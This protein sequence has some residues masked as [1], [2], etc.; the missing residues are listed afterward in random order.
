[1]IET[2]KVSP[3]ALL[4][5]SPPPPGRENLGVGV[6]S[7]VVSRWR[8]RTS[9][10]GSSRRAGTLDF[11]YHYCHRQPSLAVGW[12]A[13]LTVAGVS[14][15]LGQPPDGGP[16]KKRMMM[17]RDRRFFW[18]GLALLVF[19]A[20]VAYSG[21]RQL[22]SKRQHPAADRR[23][24]ASVPLPAKTLVGLSE[25]G[26][27]PVAS[28]GDRFSQSGDS[29][30]SEAPPPA[31]E[32]FDGWS[33]FRGPHGQGTSEDRQ[34]PWTWSDEQNLRWKCELPGAGASSPIL[35]KDEVFV[36]SYSGYGLDVSR[37]GDIRQ[38]RRQ[39]SCIDRA[40]GSIRWTREEAALM[41]EDP[42]QGMGLPEHGYATNT[43]VTDGTRVYVFFG[44]SGVLAYDMQGKLLWKVS[45]GTE[46]G[47]RGWGTAASLI[48]HGDTLIV[49]ASEES[50]AI[51]A[52]DS[53]TGEKRWEAAA[54]LLELAYG[55]PVLVPVDEERTDLV[56]A[57]PQEVWGLDPATG[58]L[59]WYA[60]MD[61]TG[62]VS[63]SVVYDKSRIYVYGGYRS[64]G[65]L[66]IRLGGLGDVT[67]THIAWTSRSSSYVAT[68]VLYQ[69]RLY[70]IDDRGQA[71]CQDASSGELIYRQRVENLES[72]GRPVYASPLVIDGRIYVQTRESG[73][74]VL[75]GSAEYNLLAQNRLTS[76]SSVF[77]ATPAVSRGQLFLRS[78]QALYCVEAK[79][80]R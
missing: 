70:W 38:L 63:P 75:A 61:L 34:V 58:K 68:P 78:N 55:T 53:R 30:A 17:G 43:P 52:L 48:L 13:A 25:A 9:M 47:N 5:R 79:A 69:D 33:R 77:N 36:T 57:V 62:N 22:Q 74:L 24:M 73:V 71:Y 44:K 3:R 21:F 1:M 32:A 37:P 27:E 26:V 23:P 12:K 29:G 64:A 39:I 19:I 80:T 16:K 42:Y 59:R 28:A 76:D 7:G 46:S 2:R 18:L 49:N 67:K 14:R 56:L 45:V 54:S 35:T 41:P 50:Q 6:A 15:R 4:A 20:T 60:S 11:R 8:E 31:S 66:A 51:L 72:G 40:T 65:S 10:N